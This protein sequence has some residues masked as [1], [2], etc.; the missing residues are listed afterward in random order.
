MLEV[1]V[2][3]VFGMLS[4]G[5]LLYAY[6]CWRG[7]F[8]DAPPGWDPQ[9]QGWYIRDLKQ[10]GI[11]D[12]LYWKANNLNLAYETAKLH[13]PFFQILERKCG[14]LKLDLYYT[15]RNAGMAWVSG[16][17][18]ACLTLR[19]YLERNNLAE[20]NYGSELKEELP[21]DRSRFIV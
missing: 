18:D 14:E 7:P 9:K 16:P 6:F 8:Y 10:P 2:W 17:P 5:V 21:A 4:A 19:R 1:L 12:C 3:I 11:D 15:I 13:Q 20:V